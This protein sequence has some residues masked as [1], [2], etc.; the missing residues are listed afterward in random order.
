MLPW[1]RYGVQAQRAAGVLEP[2][3]LPAKHFVQEDYP[4]EIAAAVHRITT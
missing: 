1:R 4:E 3:M 2:I